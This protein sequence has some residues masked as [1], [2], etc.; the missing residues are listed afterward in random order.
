MDVKERICQAESSLKITQLGVENTKNIQ[1]GDH[2]ESDQ[3][4]KLPENHAAV[5]GKHELPAKPTIKP[6]PSI[7]E[8]RRELKDL[9]MQ[10]PRLERLC[11]RLEDQQMQY[12]TADRLLCQKLDIPGPIFGDQTKWLQEQISAE[13]VGHVDVEEVVRPQ[14]SCG[15][16]YDPGELPEDGQCDCRDFD[17]IVRQLQLAKDQ[18]AVMEKRKNNL[19]KAVK[20]AWAIR[21]R[22]LV[23]GYYHTN[24]IQSMINI[25]NDIAHRGDPILDALLL[26]L[27]TSEPSLQKVFAE[28]MKLRGLLIPY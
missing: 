6:C 10:D 17:V 28:P 24:L 16:R 21:D 18:F 13:G 1:S 23:K 7:E 27:G 4:A 26:Y 11:G 15:G 20:A 14:C 3:P 2:I 25:G 19:E 22:F 9:Q 12:I 5:E 8:R